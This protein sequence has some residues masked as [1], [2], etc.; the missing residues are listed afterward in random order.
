MSSTLGQSE[1][2]V[3][4]FRRTYLACIN[5]RRRK[6]RCDLGDP[7]NP[8]TVCARCRRERRRCVFEANTRRSLDPAFKSTI[9]IAGSGI[10]GERAG[11]QARTTPDPEESPNHFSTM[12]GALSFLANAADLLASDDSKDKDRDNSNSI[13]SSNSI[14]NSIPNNTP[15]VNFNTKSK[16]ASDLRERVPSEASLSLTSGDTPRN[17]DKIPLTML[18]LG[19]SYSHN[20]RDFGMFSLRTDPR[21]ILCASESGA[22]IN[23]E[24]AHD[25]NRSL[26][27][28]AEDSTLYYETAHVSRNHAISPTTRESSMRQ[29]QEPGFPGETGVHGIVKY[30]RILKDSHGSLSSLSPRHNFISDQSIL[31]S[32]EDVEYIGN[33][34]ILSAAESEFYIR[35][36]FNTLHPFF[37]HVPQFLHL[38]KVL[39]GYPLLLC[40]ILTISTR[41][42]SLNEE[43]S[44]GMPKN[45]K[46]HEELWLHVQGMISR[47]VWAEASTRSI[48][49]VFAFLLLT[50]WNPRAIHWR[51]T[52]YANN[53]EEMADIRDTEAMAGE[54]P[55]NAGP[56]PAGLGAMRRSFRMAWMLIGSA[57]RLAQDMAFMEMSSCSFVATHITEINSVMNMKR[58]SMLSHSLAEIDLLSYDIS[59]AEM[60]AREE[61]EY[62]VLTPRERSPIGPDYR[63]LMFT[64]VQ[65]AQIELL[66]IISLG[67]ESLYG[68]KAQLG[69]LTQR[70]NLAILNIM[71]PMIKNWGDKYKKYLVP[72][73]SKAIAR[74]S[75]KDVKEARPEATH[76][77]RQLMTNESFIFDYNY[78]KLY[79]FSLALSPSPKSRTANKEGKIA[80]KLDEISQSA[81]YIEQA[82]NAANEILQVSHRVH[83]L[84]MLKFMPVRWVT[85]IVRAVAF[86]VKCYLTITAHK[87]T[88]AKTGAPSS[89]ED[90]DS[91]VLSLSLI[92]VDQIV[93]SIYDAAVTLRDCS[94]D[95]LHLCTNYSKIL[96]YLYSEMKSSLQKSAGDGSDTAGEQM[97]IP[98][99]LSL[100]EPK[101]SQTESSELFGSSKDIPDL[102]E[103]DLMD[104]F[105]NNRDFG[106]LDFVWP[107][108]EVIEQQLEKG[109]LAEI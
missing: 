42:H 54:F 40:S 98:P 12:N 31:R 13:S 69:C 90:F 28:Q 2:S 99:P 53:A 27:R 38:P 48:G 86:I 94:P 18:S 89:N 102:L 70:Q 76:N 75:F 19:S 30:A 103:N 84:N 97:E 92:S 8:D 88:E 25:P 65:R 71:S 73:K 3:K 43:V 66:Q 5:C 49:T 52:D 105:I 58:R 41:Y 4:H 62:N 107:W 20:S 34:G 1:T 87:S 60:E 10:P 37:P 79:I 67:H 109:G 82:F 83:K 47:T 101:T 23:G 55:M 93:K 57:V 33:L 36:F 45:L 68:Y 80:L 77:L 44:N 32:L 91:T 14:S 56:E 29:G 106:G 108:T 16:N 26:K 11:S 9:Q 7:A 95:E 35:M 100:G 46:I 51:V 78:T 50:E 59:E 22:S 96:F 61:Q 6:V 39:S 64:E 85:K 74:I 72:S 24:R 17:D 21:S 81:I 63:P 104:W 15:N